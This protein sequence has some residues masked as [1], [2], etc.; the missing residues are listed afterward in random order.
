[1]RMLPDS[2]ELSLD[3]VGAWRGVSGGFVQDERHG[4]RLVSKWP[5]AKAVQ[6]CS[7]SWR[8]YN[9]KARKAQPE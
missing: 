4:L 9:G 1:M 6:S 5:S 2:L 3:L 7:P 8:A